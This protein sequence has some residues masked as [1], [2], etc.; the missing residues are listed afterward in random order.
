MRPQH[1]SAP[2][3]NDSEKSSLTGPVYLPHP[4]LT[5]LFSTSTLHHLPQ[6]QTASLHLRE[7]TAGTPL[8]QGLYTRLSLPG[9]PRQ[10]QDLRLQPRL[11]LNGSCLVQISLLLELKAGCF[12][13]CLPGVSAPQREPLTHLYLIVFSIFP[14]L[15]SKIQEAR[16]C[17]CPPVARC[18]D[19]VT[20]PQGAQC[21]YAELV[22]TS[23]GCCP[24]LCWRPALKKLPV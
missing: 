13:L 1:S 20:A 16:D 2:N 23:T 21:A 15:E 6:P 10:P 9:P 18:L 17:L 14:G 7:E 3:S 5:Y 12:V 8:P 11:C 19:S 22:N 4:Q 24:A